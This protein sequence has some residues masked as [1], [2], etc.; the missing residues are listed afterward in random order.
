MQFNLRYHFDHETHA[1][2]SESQAKFTSAADNRYVS[3]NYI[4]MTLSILIKIDQVSVLLS[5]MY[6]TQKYFII[7][8]KHHIVTAE[9]YTD[10]LLCWWQPGFPFSSLISCSFAQ[11]HVYQE[12]DI[13][14]LP[15]FSCP[16][17]PAPSLSYHQVSSTSRRKWKS[18][19]FGLTQ[20]RICSPPT[21][22]CPWDSPAD[23]MA[24]IAAT[25]LQGSLLGPGIEPRPPHCR[26]ML[27]SLHH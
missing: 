3:Y 12:E 14:P 1:Q 17:L 10:A 13:Q 18:L 15:S 6:H 26:Q 24:L 5:D 23:R 7:L 16:L 22:S 4:F 2:K 20:H 27:N 9:L 21:S 25:L 11:T 8:L 19:Q